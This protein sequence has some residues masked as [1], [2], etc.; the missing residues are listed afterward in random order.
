MFLWLSLDINGLEAF[1][2]ISCQALLACGDY[3]ASG[4]ERV[5]TSWLAVDWELSLKPV[6]LNFTQQD[7]LKVCVSEQ[8]AVNGNQSLHSMHQCLLGVMG[9]ALYSLCHMSWSSLLE[10]RQESLQVCWLEILNSSIWIVHVLVLPLLR[11]IHYI[12]PLEDGLDELS[13]VTASS[14]L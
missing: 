4:H 10:H 14:Q 13:S 9:E 7:I 2:S 6:T 3:I 5:R 12:T 11:H 8:V 1:G